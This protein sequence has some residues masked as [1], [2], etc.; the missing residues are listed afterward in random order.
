VET[1]IVPFLDSNK[2]P[3]QFVSIRNEITERKRLAAIIEE[4]PQRIL[5]AQEEE[6]Q[7][8]ALDIHDDLGQS[9][10]ALKMRIQTTFLK[11][12]DVKR[13]R[14]GVHSEIINSLDRIIDRTRYLAAGLRPSTF[15]VLGLS[16]S[17]RVLVDEFSLQKRI[18]I[19]FHHCEIDNLKFLGD[20]INL[21]RIIQEALTNIFRHSKASKAKIKM[22]RKNTMLFVDVEDNGR[23][24]M[25]LFDSK[26]KRAGLG[27]STMRERAKL[28]KGEMSI[29][30]CK[31]G[32]T[33]IQFK[34]PVELQ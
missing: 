8:I 16:S 32:R 4:L 30:P 24:G 14:K 2:K 10:A 13:N 6:R 25:E 23:G 17:L 12:N 34:I 9:L 1:T 29:G 33:V 31:N 22:Q 11:E 3:Y 15:D 21:Y 7:R 27:L 5:D 26:E 19:T 18:E 20:K 28:L